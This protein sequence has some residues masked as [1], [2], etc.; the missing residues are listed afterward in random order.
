[1]KPIAR[2]RKWF[3]Y[4]AGILTV[5]PVTIMFM[6]M[7]FE[8][9]GEH[10]WVVRFQG[11][12]FWLLAIAGYGALWIANRWR[13]AFLLKKFGRDIQKNLK[14]GIVCIFSNPLAEMV[15]IM[16]LIFAVAFIISL[17]TP[18]RD[19]YYVV[20]MLSCFIWA[21]NMHCLFN[22]KIY[23]ITKFDHKERKKL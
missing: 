12:V 18:L 1:M 23:R 11:A 8:L 14:P 21:V 5:L 3:W 4:S 7:I 15:D 20:V 10:I 22:G 17:C 19:T 13:K 9:A 6:P 16:F 2:I